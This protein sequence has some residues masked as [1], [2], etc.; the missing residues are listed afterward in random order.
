MS[1]RNTLRAL[2]WH[3]A[4][5]VRLE[6]VPDP[7]PPGPG[8]ITVDVEWCGI[9]GTDVEEYTDGPLVIPSRPHA[10]TGLS[11]PMII[12]HEV[13]GRVS[14]AG[15]GAGLAPGTLVALDGYLYCGSCRACARH[16]VNLC[17]RWAHIGMSSPGGLAERVVVPARMAMPAL[18]DIPSDQ[19]ALAEPFSVGVRAVRR[20]RLALGERVAIIGGGTIGLAVAQVALT[21]GAA[22]VVVAD[23]LP[24]RRALARRFGAHEAAAVDVLHDGP[25]GGFDIVF[26]CTGNVDVPN[27]LLTLP[28]AGG[29]IVL[30][31]IPPAAGKF[32]FKT[33]VLREL[34]VI[35]SV[36]HVFDEDMLAAVSLLCSGRV[37]AA[38][39][40]THRIGLERAVPDGI[41]FLA[42]EGRSSALKILV[43]PRTGGEV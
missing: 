32:D 19:L 25:H 7:A 22:H 18:S 9:C 6:E 31:G 16:Q 12:G 13:A 29:R 23:P 2:R 30:V 36:G 33:V 24:H 41:Q 11:A 28:R 14:A 20:A 40:I 21:A 10:L 4:G 37:D 15:P 3:A 5:D 35:G 34:S 8:E 39:L 27:S 1:G 43:S 26:D 38:S 42:G 17:D